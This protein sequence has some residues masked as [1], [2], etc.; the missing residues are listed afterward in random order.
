MLMGRGSPKILNSLGPLS[1]IWKNVGFLSHYPPQ[2]TLWGYVVFTPRIQQLCLCF[3][4]RS[5]Q[6][7][8]DHI[9]SLLILAKTQPRP[10]II[11]VFTGGAITAL[12]LLQELHSRVCLLVFLSTGLMRPRMGIGLVYPVAR[13]VRIRSR[14]IQL[15]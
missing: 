15:T 11:V 1:L 13:F 14:M 6:A 9:R 12:G 5:R 3:K 2:Q 7:K 4:L 10:Y 8:V